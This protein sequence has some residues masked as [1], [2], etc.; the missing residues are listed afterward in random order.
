MREQKFKQIRE[1]HRKVNIERIKLVFRCMGILEEQEQ[2]VTKKILALKLGLTPSQVESSIKWLLIY[3]LIR[4][5]YI[6]SKGS[7]LITKRNNEGKFVWGEELNQVIKNNLSYI[8]EAIPSDDFSRLVSLRKNDFWKFLV[9]QNQVIDLLRE[10]NFTE[11]GL[12]KIQFR[13]AEIRYA[14]A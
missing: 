14:I 3:N 1:E 9:V 13:N 2:E 4:K 8:E 12:W 5:H 7:F 11:D 10:N 6:G